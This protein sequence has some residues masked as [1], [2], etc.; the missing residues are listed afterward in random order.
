MGL[1]GAQKSRWITA[2]FCWKRSSLFQLDFFVVHVLASFGIKFLDQHLLGRGLLVFG[3]GVEVAGSSG[4]FQLDLLACAFGCHVRFSL[5]LT[6]CAQVGE[7]GV[8]AVFVDQAKG[9]TGDAQTHPAVFALDP[10]TAVLQVRQEPA[11]GFVV[12][13]GNIVPDH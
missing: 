2:A 13:V 7:H 5:S 6:A 3:G 4:G 1:N 10:E 8:N 12:G 9:G 11:L